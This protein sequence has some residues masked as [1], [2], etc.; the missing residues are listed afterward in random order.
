M[1]V[2]MGKQIYLASEEVENRK[3]LG[4]AFLGFPASDQL[5]SGQEKF[6]HLQC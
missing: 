2:I 5:L 4:I 3:M 6:L 1:T